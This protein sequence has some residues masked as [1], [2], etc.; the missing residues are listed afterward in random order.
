MNT[1]LNS[2][3]RRRG[4]AIPVIIA[5]ALSSVLLAFSMTPTFSA[6]SAE[7]TNSINTAGTGTLVMQETGPNSSGNTVTCT[8]DGGGTA[9][10]ASINKFGAGMAMK[11]GATVSIPITIKNAGSLPAS[12]FTV[13]ANPC[14]DQV[15][16]TA[17]VSGT[18]TNLCDLYSVK[19]VK[20]GTPA[21]TVQDTITLTNFNTATATTPVSIGAVAAGASVDLTLT[22]TLSTSASAANQGRYVS[23]PIIWTFQA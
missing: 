3:A 18:G 19:I 14:E 7:I 23:Q 2:D 6:L 22:V 16:T 1:E 10:C 5:G 13:K 21:T 9:T 20:S 17:T 12:T 4:F 15:Q 11:P 8:T